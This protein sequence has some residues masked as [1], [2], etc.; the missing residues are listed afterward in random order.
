MSDENEDVVDDDATNDDATNDDANPKD[1]AKVDNKS[2]DGKSDEDGAK[3]EGKEG[4]GDEDVKTG[5]FT[6]LKVPEGATIDPTWLAKFTDNEAI[7]G[8]TQPQAEGLLGLLHEYQQ[9]QAAE[10]TEFWK[11]K[12]VEW[13]ADFEGNE[14]VKKVGSE[15]A[16]SLAAAARETFFPGIG[17]ALEAIGMADLGSHPA[18]ALGMVKIA[19]HFKL[20][21][22]NPHGGRPPAGGRKSDAASRWYPNMTRSPGADAA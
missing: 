16:Q 12:S 6:D 1:D 15:E 14:D 5:D 13:K 21:E 8:L 9:H 11:T 18:I 22:E 3:D 10:N 7:Q 20:L 2:S 17:E 4:N 19:Q